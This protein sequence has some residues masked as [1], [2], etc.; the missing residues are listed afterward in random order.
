VEILRGHPFGAESSDGRDE[1]S[2]WINRNRPNVYSFL[3]FWAAGGARCL[4]AYMKRDYA[5]CVA[6]GQEVLSHHF[7]PTVALVTIVALR[8]LSRSQEAGVLG[9]SLLERSFGPGGMFL[10]FMMLLDGVIDPKEFL[11][12]RIFGGYPVE[13]TRK[14]ECQVFFY[15]GAK[16]LTEERFGEAIS[17][18]LLSI[19]TEC[20]ALERCLAEADLEVATVLARSGKRK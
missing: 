18:L 6:S 19:S 9:R 1:L 2:D 10:F 20:D 14:L 12:A 11:R 13:V 7:I 15:W 4:S 16:L 3:P 5:G 17:P 8:R